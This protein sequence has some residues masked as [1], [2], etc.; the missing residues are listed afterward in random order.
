M[1]SNSI[2][3]GLSIIGKC[4]LCGGMVAQVYRVWL[5]INPPVASCTA[6]GAVKD[7]T[8]NLPTI[9]MKNPGIASSSDNIL[10]K[11]FPNQFH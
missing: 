1:I 3:P 4:S 6:C 7:N 2:H 11:M 8:F 10:K 9:P 5:G